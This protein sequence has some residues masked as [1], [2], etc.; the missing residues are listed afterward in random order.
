LAVRRDGWKYIRRDGAVDQLFDLR[1]DPG[2]R[3]NRIQDADVARSLAQ[4]IEDYEADMPQGLESAGLDEEVR[5]NLR[6][7]GYAE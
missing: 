4:A 7:L 1:T 3:E 6:A 5:K 2:E